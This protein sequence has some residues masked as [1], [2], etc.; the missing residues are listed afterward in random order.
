MKSILTA[1]LLLNFSMIYAQTTITT[2]YPPLATTFST[3]VTAV[4][5]SVRNNNAFPV[6]LTNITNLQGPL[7]AENGY[8]LYYSTTSQGGVPYPAAPYVYGPATWLGPISSDS[9]FSTTVFNSFVTPFDC[10]GLTIPANTTYRFALQ[11]T[12]GT[13]VRGAT[14]TPN[15]FSGGG[16]DL[17]VGNFAGVGGNVGY[18]TW[19][20]LGWNTPFFFDGSIT[21]APLNTYTDIQVKS[22]TSTQMQ[23]Q[24]AMLTNQNVSAIVCNKST[25][26]Y[27]FRHQ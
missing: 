22:I 14:A 25:Q 8:K 12:K 2:A 13:S 5:F 15:I 1:L 11:G 7:F 4:T 16:V 20:N 17:L 26:T 24:Y 3:G 23:I 18:F 6:I 19:D 27:N 10:I 21:V 9:V